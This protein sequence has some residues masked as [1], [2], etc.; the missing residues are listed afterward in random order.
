MIAAA[1]GPTRGGERLTIRIKSGGMC[2]IS[3]ARSVRSNIRDPLFSR[4]CGGR[5]IREIKGMRIFRVLQ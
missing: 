3:W 5:E 4:I 2:V 1:G